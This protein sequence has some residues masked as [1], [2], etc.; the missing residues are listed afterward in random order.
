[1]KPANV[2]VY[3]LKGIPILYI[4]YQIKV[5]KLAPRRNDNP[6]RSIIS[7]LGNRYVKYQPENMKKMVV[8]AKKLFMFYLDKTPFPYISSWI[9][10]SMVVNYFLIYCV[11]FPYL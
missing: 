10:I 3:R 1:M 5:V 4:P 11:Y 2:S 7:I 8:I 6:I 9:V